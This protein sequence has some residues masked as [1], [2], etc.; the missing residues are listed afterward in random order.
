MYSLN[1]IT[2]SEVEPVANGC[3]RYRKGNLE[4]KEDCGSKFVQTGISPFHSYKSCAAYDLVTSHVPLST[5]S[6]SSFHC[7]MKSI[8]IVVSVDSLLALLSALL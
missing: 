6:Y 7:H 5:W 3:H 1:L 4:K 2:I 8:A